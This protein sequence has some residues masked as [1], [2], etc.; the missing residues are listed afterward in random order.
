MLALLMLT[1]LLTLNFVVAAAEAQI[2]YPHR[3]GPY[4]DKV[5]FP[6]IKD[7]T[8]RLLA[9]EAGELS[10]VTIIP[11]HLERV[12]TSRPDAHIIFVVGFSFAG[13]LHF[14]V[15][16]WPVKYYEL[17][18][19]LAHLWNRDKIIAESPLRGVA[20]KCTTLLPPTYGVW[21]NWDADYE[22]LYPYDPAKASEWLSRIFT[23]CTGPD[24]KPAW[25]DPREGGRVVEIEILSLPEATS[26][27]Y[28][29]IAGYIKAEAEAV[30][31]RVKIKAVS[32]REMDAAIAAG[33]AQAWI[34]GW[35]FLRLPSWLQELLHS[36]N[37]RPGGWNEWRVNDSRLD[38]LLDRFYFTK[39]IR[40]AMEYGWRIQELVVREIIP[41]IPTYT[42]VGIAAFDGAIDRGSLDLAL[43]YAPPGKEPTVYSWYYWKHTVRFKDRKFGGVINYYHTVD[44]TTYHPA[45]WLWS[46]E[47]EVVLLVYP[48]PRFLKT[49]NIYEESAPLIVEDLRV[50]EVE[51]GGRKLYRFTITLVKGVRW[52]DGVEVT[53]ED[54]AYTI[55][56]FG[57]ELKTRWYYGPDI[58]QMVDIKVINKT[59]LEIY[60]KDY[61]WVDVFRYSEEL[62]I[63]PKHIFERLANPLEDPSTLPHPTVPGLTAMVGYGPYAMA[64]REILYSELV[65]NPWYFWRYPER[66]VKFE[67][68]TLPAEVSEGS[69]FKVSVTLVDYLDSRA[70]N[71]SVT[72]KLVGPMTL[73]L[74]ATHV[75]GGVYEATVPG[76]R[77]G[78]YTVEIYAEQPIMRWSVDNV[79]RTKISVRAVVGP[80]L[81][82]PV[83]ERPPPVV[84][85]IPGIPPVEITPPPAIALAAPKVEVTTPVIT[86]A[87]TEAVPEVERAVAGVTPATM[88]Y[89]AA[90]LAVVA[91]GV[92]A[93]R[94]K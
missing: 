79:Y 91:L 89:A 30:G 75:G 85:K 37:I 74:A 21:V 32:S 26:P 54:Y 93:I 34:I 81:V 46:T 42:A 13:A 36:R 17:R 25:C 73:T 80:P 67:S 27:V 90:V 33:T 6:V 39:N 24:G 51:Y 22:R 38:A 47:G 58:E 92:A 57:K 16:A 78:T 18:A 62:Y 66:T 3:Y 45:M 84:V 68:V 49:T 29:W 48:W 4:V 52:Q 63:L 19:A 94:R 12:R 69:P 28:W 40:E 60:F 61:G 55:L 5:T 59:T 70:T 20:I 35:G 53:A 72:V 9:F 15:Q 82:G 44:I 56:K 65:W 76:L 88:V 11:A 14:N 50:D 7:Y 43:A 41:W 64:K 10:A 1:G 31:L 2:E 86:L 77:A 71:A 87:S 23:P 8:V 83:V